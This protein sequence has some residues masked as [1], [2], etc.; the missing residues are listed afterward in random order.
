MAINYFGFPCVPRE[1]MRGAGRVAPGIAPR[2]SHRSVRAQLRHTAR[3]V[4][5]S[6]RT[7]APTHGARAGALAAGTR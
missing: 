7:V 2:R 5:G 1:A 6:L 4:M 3:Q